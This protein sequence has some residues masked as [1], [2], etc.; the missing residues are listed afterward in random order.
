METG[1][2]DFIAGFRFGTTN[3]RL[4]LNTK[5]SVFVTVINYQYEKGVLVIQKKLIAH[6]LAY[7]YYVYDGVRCSKMY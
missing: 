1:F 6:Y 2:C 4:I 3:A 7:R 5:T